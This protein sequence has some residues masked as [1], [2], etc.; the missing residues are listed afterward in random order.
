[1]TLIPITAPAL[2]ATFASA[3]ECMA[4]LE[5]TIPVDVVEI[6]DDP[7]QAVMSRIDVIKWE[8]T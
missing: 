4:R 6:V 3:A 5:R 7:T 1:M 8:E 2:L